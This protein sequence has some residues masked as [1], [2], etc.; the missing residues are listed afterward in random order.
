MELVKVSRSEYDAV[1][2]KDIEASVDTVSK[3]DIEA[4]NPDESADSSFIATRNRL[5]SSIISTCNSS[6]MI[7]SFHILDALHTLLKTLTTRQPCYLGLS[8]PLGPRK[9]TL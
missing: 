4:S 2:E 3:K 8:L 9:A 5:V 7:L 6:L 1:D